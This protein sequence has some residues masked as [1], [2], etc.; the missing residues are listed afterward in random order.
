MLL[1]FLLHSF[2]G[3]V[4]DLA[5]I[6]LSLPPTSANTCLPP[7]Q[8]YKGPALK[9]LHHGG[10]EGE[11]APGCARHRAY[12]ILLREVA[13]G[14]QWSDRHPLLLCFGHHQ[15]DATFLRPTKE[16]RIN[17]ERQKEEQNKVLFSSETPKY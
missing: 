12:I 1:L 15:Q 8:V 17:Q 3:C 4:S 7:C 5:A 14:R 2:A 6:S 9:T 11:W 10:R 13:D 16:E